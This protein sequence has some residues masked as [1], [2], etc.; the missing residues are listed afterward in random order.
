MWYRRE[1]IEKVEVEIIIPSDFLVS[2]R[3]YF[4]ALSRAANP[5]CNSQIFRS[6]SV[7]EVRTGK[8][9]KVWTK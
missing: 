2:T 9:S 7:I 4:D 6:S 1:R 8:V 3:K 5:L